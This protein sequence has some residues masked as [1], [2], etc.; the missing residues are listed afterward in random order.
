MSVYVVGDVHG[1]RDALVDALRAEGLVDSDGNW[2]GAEDRLW[3]LGDFTD[4]GPDGVGV[5]DLVRGLQAQAAEAGGSVQMLLGNHEILLL[6]MYHFGDR[7]VPSDFG[8]R[9]FARSWEINGGLLSD[10]DRL[11][12][13]HIEWLTARPLV[14]VD[15]DHLLL[16]SDT[17]EYLDWGEDIDSINATAHDILSGSNIED[18]WDVWRRMTTRYAFRGPDGEEN[19]DRLLDALGGSRIVHG[20]SVIADQLGI[21]PTQIEGPYLYAGG[22]ALGIDGGLFVGGPCLVVKLPF[23]PE[24]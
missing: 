6:G 7:P 18:W 15:E 3:F 8:P 12:P 2:A 16:H 17:L 24:D 20:H 9:S 13:E 14:A 11:T 1:H 19:A 21:H 10:Q 5:I 23:E 22:K 4:R